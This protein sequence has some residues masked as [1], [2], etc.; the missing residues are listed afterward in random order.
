[1]LAE[2]HV[3]EVR[4]GGDLELGKDL[5]QVVV[6][7]ARAEEQLRGNLRVGPPGVRDTAV[8]GTETPIV[9]SPTSSAAGPNGEG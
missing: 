1:M 5:A 3:R 6:D 2:V 9:G 4:T 8:A 7:R